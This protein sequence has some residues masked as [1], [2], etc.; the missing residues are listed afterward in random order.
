MRESSNPA[1]SSLTKTVARGQAGAHHYGQQQYGPGGYGPGGYGQDPYGQGAYGQ[2]QYGAPQQMQDARPMTVDDVVSKT[3][4][5]LAVIVALAAVNFAI[6][7]FVSLG[8]SMMLTI[9]GAIGGLIMV[10]ISTFGKKFGSAPVT[11]TYAVFEGLLVGGVSFLFAGFNVAGSNGFALISQ[12]V[13]ATIGVFAG[14]LWVYKSGAIR[15]TPKFTRFM[16]AALIGVVVLMVG[17]FLLAF[18]TGMSPLRDGGPIAII[19]SLVCIGLAAFSFL[20]DFD[21]ADKLVRAGAPATYAWGVALGLA[22]TLVWLYIEIL[23][24]LSYF[25]D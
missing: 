17:N 23:R 21:Q 7:Q 1:F 3:G 20:L 22:V 15:V 11:L 25:R 6:A 10:L 12:A 24:L 8:L 13:I 5:T 4:I 16:M 2:E 9:V 18:F 19:F 14:M